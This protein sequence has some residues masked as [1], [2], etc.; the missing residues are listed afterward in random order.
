LV[1]LATI[2]PLFG[3]FFLPL[4]LNIMPQAMNIVPLPVRRDAG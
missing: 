2:L 1:G 4:A 3:D